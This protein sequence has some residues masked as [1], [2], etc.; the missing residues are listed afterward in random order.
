MG[1]CLLSVT[2]TS[3]FPPVLELFISLLCLATM[4]QFYSPEPLT[5]VE[6]VPYPC[7]HLRWDRKAREVWS[8][9][10]A[11][12]PDDKK[13]TKSFLLWRRSLLWT[14]FGYISQL[15]LFLFPWQGSEMFVG[16][17]SW[18]PVRFLGV[19]HREVRETPRRFSLS[20]LMSKCNLQQYIKITI[21]MFLLC[22]HSIDYC[23][24]CDSLFTPISPD[25]GVRI[26]PPTFILWWM[27]EKSLIHNCQKLEATRVSFN[28][29]M[30]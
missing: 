30:D 23:S 16:F 20:C 26:F 1:L 9:R 27:L 3:F 22:Y 25:L 8:G 13:L 19:N 4:F 10:K 28:R 21:Q 18:E 7:S 2:F 12:S 15:I 5:S 29:L 24:M 14:R 11:L 17:L 6:D